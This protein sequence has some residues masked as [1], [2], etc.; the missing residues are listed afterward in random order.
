M[1]DQTDVGPPAGKVG[2]VPRRDEPFVLEDSPVIGDLFLL[3]SALRPLLRS[4]P[5][6]ERFQSVR[7]VGAETARVARPLSDEGAL[8]EVR[9]N[10]RTEDEPG[11]R[12]GERACPIRR[13]DLVGWGVADEVVDAIDE[14]VRDADSAAVTEAKQVQTA[15]A[16]EAGRI[17]DDARSRT[18][19]VGRING[20]DLR[21]RVVDESLD[22]HVPN[23]GRSTRV[24]TTHYREGKGVDM[25]LLILLVVLIVL[26]FGGGFGYGEGRYRGPGIGLGG[27]LLIVLL[28]L[29]LTGNLL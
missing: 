19:K 3:E 8:I 12:S 17:T 1:R 11:I 13:E 29:L 14:L 21:P 2:H 16:A 23:S 25:L 5:C 20:E 15:V 7:V 10:G 26:A 18:A 27:I 9:V 28:V 24:W 4:D 22:V 6:T